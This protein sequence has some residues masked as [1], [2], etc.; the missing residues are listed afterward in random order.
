[1]CGSMNLSVYI[2]PVH[3]LTKMCRSFT[4]PCHFMSLHFCVWHRHSLWQHPLI[5]NLI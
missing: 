2:D 5:Q 3:R 4:C 1:M